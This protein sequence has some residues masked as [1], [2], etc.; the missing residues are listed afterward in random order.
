MGPS[1]PR[2]P[3]QAS[4]D[5]L[6]SLVVAPPLPA[7]L[8]LA[9]L[10]AAEAQLCAAGTLGARLWALCRAA[11]APRERAAA[12][13][14]ACL[15]GACFAAV[16]ARLQDSARAE[17]RM[18]Q[19]DKGQ[20]NGSKD[21]DQT[22]QAALAADG[23]GEAEADTLAPRGGASHGRFVAAVAAARELAHGEPPPLELLARW[24]ACCA[25]AAAAAAALHLES[26]PAAA[27]PGPAAADD[28]SGAGDGALRAWLRAACQGQA[29]GAAGRGG[30]AGGAAPRS[31][32][33][34]RRPLPLV[35]SGHAASLTPY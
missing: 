12:R 11:A 26:F 5:L 21:S 16:G 34:G 9:L 22:D 17:A 6:R 7:A 20:M 3:R 24:Q 15:R 1:D 29:A 19:S 23:A 27:A 33:V 31:V 10:A 25:S 14:T 32:L 2:V 18:A 35:L 13:G 28:G 4:A 30:P 8:A